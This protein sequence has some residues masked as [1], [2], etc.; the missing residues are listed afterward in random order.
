MDSPK[1]YYLE[2]DGYWGFH[3]AL[4]ACAYRSIQDRRAFVVVTAYGVLP[5]QRDFY[6]ELARE[7]D[8]IFLTGGLVFAVAGNPS[9]YNGENRIW[10]PSDGYS[11]AS[12]GAQ[13]M[14][15][16]QFADQ[17]TG[18]SWLEN[19]VKPGDLLL[20]LEVTVV[21]MFKVLQVSV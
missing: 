8:E 10:M 12:V 18:P 1:V 16:T 14:D 7:S 15:G 3:E 6:D 19:R 13:L 20:L 2:V 4:H 21:Q 9:N 5:S 17:C 11:T